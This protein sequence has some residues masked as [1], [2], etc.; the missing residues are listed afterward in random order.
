MI[1][2]HDDT[3]IYYTLSGEG[4][5]LVLLHG[6]LE[7][8]SIWDGML[9]SLEERYTVLTIDL[10]GHGK[11]EG[12]A[13]VH[14]MALFA[15]VVHS[16]LRALEI[17]RAT[18]LGHSMGGYVALAMADLYP[19]TVNRLL[20]LN[21]TPA[22]DS[23]ERKQN[24]KRALKVLAQNP[25]AFVRMAIANLFTPEAQARHS[26]TIAQLQQEALRFPVEGIQAAIRGMIVR[27]DRSDVLRKF[28]KNA[29]LLAGTN[30]LIVPIADLRTVSETTG[31]P[32]RELEGGH[33]G[34]CENSSK[35]EEILHFID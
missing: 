3:P 17:Y 24:R 27:P 33:M 20:L 18:F 26:A 1:Y 6:F 15:T 32:V 5:H 10:P 4:P 16:L 14:T 30:D 22:A 13:D 19:H 28:A 7:S 23:K 2:H 9:A 31:A 35:I 29:L 11:S 8:S 34:W 25:T 21:S 12:L